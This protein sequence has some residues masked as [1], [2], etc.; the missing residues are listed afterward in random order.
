MYKSRTFDFGKMI[1]ALRGIITS[2]TGLQVVPT[3]NKNLP[4]YPYITYTPPDAYK[5]ET[6]GNTHE[7]EM[8]T[9]NVVLNCYAET[10]QESVM[11]ADDIVTFLFDPNYHEQLKRSGIVVVSADPEGESSADFA[12]MFQISTQVVV[13]KLRLMRGYIADFPNITDTNIGGH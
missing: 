1:G 11:I 12:Q 8:F 7:E 2:I 4:P 13:L 3:T 9:V 5:A 6:W 10:P